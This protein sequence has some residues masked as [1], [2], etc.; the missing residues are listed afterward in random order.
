VS[1]TLSS[2]KVHVPPERE[3]CGVNN[4]GSLSCNDPRLKIPDYFRGVQVGDLCTNA[5]DY[6]AVFKYVS[7]MRMKLIKCERKLNQRGR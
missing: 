4:E 6:N 7:D 2:C 3:L 1:L 5:R